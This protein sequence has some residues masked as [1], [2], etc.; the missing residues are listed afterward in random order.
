MLC[1][2]TSKYECNYTPGSS[3]QQPTVTLVNIPS[4]N[5]SNN[6]TYNVRQ[7]LGPQPTHS[8][9][10]QPI[11]SSNTN[12]QYYQ[13]NQVRVATFMHVTIFEIN[14]FGSLALRFQEMVQIVGH[15]SRNPVNPP[16]LHPY[17]KVIDTKPS[18]LN[19]IY[20]LF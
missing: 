10:H 2:F 18:K 16:P 3:V 7:N 11:M 14:R 17:K 13:Q 5:V 15:F 19:Q 20:F 6:L 8:H 9:S 12:W 1:L 4:S